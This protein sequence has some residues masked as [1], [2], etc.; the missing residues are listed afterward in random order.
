[1]MLTSLYKLPY[2]VIQPVVLVEPHCSA[3]SF[4]V[5]RTELPLGVGE[6]NF[7]G[8][9]RQTRTRLPFFSP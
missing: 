2:V 3:G 1:M 7:L 4:L 9:G 5:L 8:K 6:W